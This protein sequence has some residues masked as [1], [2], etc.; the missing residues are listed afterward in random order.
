MLHNRDLARPCHSVLPLAMDFISPLAWSL[1]WQAKPVPPTG[2]I[3]VGKNITVGRPKPLAEHATRWPPHV[4]FPPALKRCDGTILGLLV[5]MD[6]NSNQHRGLTR[7]RSLQGYTPSLGT[8]RLEGRAR[9][10]ETTGV[11][12]TV[13]QRGGESDVQEVKGHVSPL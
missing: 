7:R 13:E 2:F 12:K 10:F 3:A 1:R 5:R 8:L 6:I 11:R 4:V 9:G